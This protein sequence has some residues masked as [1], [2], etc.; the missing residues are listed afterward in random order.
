[1][2]VK[3]NAFNKSLEAKKNEEIWRCEKKRKEKICSLS[4]TIIVVS[5]NHQSIIRNCQ[6]RKSMRKNTKSLIKFLSPIF[7][8]L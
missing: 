6:K 5:Y 7:V 3:I 2:K 8:N 4:K 1:M